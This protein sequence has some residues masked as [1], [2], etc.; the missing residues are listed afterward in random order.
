MLVDLDAWIT[1][2]KTLCKPKNVH[3]CD[4]SEEEYDQ[5][6]QAL[7]DSRTFVPL[8]PSLR[9]HSFWCHSTPEDVSRSEE[10]T[11][12]CSSSKADSGPTN[13]WADPQEMK[14]KLLQLF[15][16]CMQGRTLYVIPFRMG[17]QYGVQITDSPYVVVSMRIMTRMGKEILSQITSFI[18][19]LHSVGVPLNPGAIDASWP[20]CS[21]QKLIVHF[22]DEPS[23]WSF[24]SGYGGNAL[25]SKKCLS[26]RIAS[27]LGRR[28]G[29]LAEHMLILGL[30]NPQG[31]KK[32]ITAAFPSACGKTNLA[33]LAST[34]PDWKVTTVGD[35]IAWLRPGP[36]GRLYAINPEFGLFGVAPGTSLKSNPSAMGA[37]SKNS[38]FTNTALTDEGDVWWEGMTEHPPHHAL[39]WQGKSWDPSS[40]TK[41]AHPNA[42]FT[43]PLVQCPVLDPEWNNPDGVPISA[44]LFGGR[45][46]TT[47]PLVVEAKDW[48]QGVFFGASMSS[49][50]TAAAEGAVGKLRHDPFAMLPFCGYNMG[51]YFAHWLS[52]EKKL[53]TP[54]RIYQVNW[55]RKDK[56]G[57]Y[58]W[59]GFGENIHVL[60]WIFEHD[61]SIDTPIGRLPIPGTFKPQE[62]ISF[63]PV[64]Y[65]KEVESMQQYFT[66]FGDRFPVA[67]QKHLDSLCAQLS[68][69]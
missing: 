36:D 25:L 59:P 18:P 54:P 2:I 37:I 52:M 41:A 45:R 19:C 43:T 38:L 14:K 7:V 56:S 15:S 64:A 40:L 65:Q 13:N 66:L 61:D 35:D 24:G 31:V 44:I 4:G 8:N 42:R 3:I 23:I 27:V 55:F 47:V 9:P 51:D 46:S 32:Y 28:E 16:G 49:E 69:K 50:T 62:L 68:K 29:W 53:K 21:D 22:P 6:C 60:K 39:D 34:L 10:S 26:L 20:C 48:T 57:A 5:L 67:L 58:L 12:I 17:S 1:D 11:Y 63:D 30:T 33:M